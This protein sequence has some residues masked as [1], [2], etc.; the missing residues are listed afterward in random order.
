[1][2]FRVGLETNMEGRAI[3]W[4]LEF[5]GC[6]AY[7]ANTD[8]AVANLP[9]A[10]QRYLDWCARHGV[11]QGFTPAE[12]E[13]A[14]EETFE[15]ITLDEAFELSREGYEVDAWF[16]HDWKPLT[17][18]DVAG[19]LQRLMWSREDLMAAVEGLSPEA[20]AAPHPGER[21]SIA[22]ILRHVGGAEWWYM[23][24]LGLAFPREQVPKEPFERLKVVRAHLTAV[25]PT[26]AGSRQVTGVDG[27][28]WS[29]RK[30]LRR[31]VWH[32][33]DHVEHI[34]KLR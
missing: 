4:A 6:F 3:A 16:R 21:W 11:P 19:G 26:L 7:G 33:L 14:V 8:E 27:E 23:E 31:A 29:P 24:R 1:M 13:V 17:A 5:P 20:L 9:D 12:A 10:I 25:L 15:N 32:E 30:L 18:E 2:K 22:G 34:G 28:L